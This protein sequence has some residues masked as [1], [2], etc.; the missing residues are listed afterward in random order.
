MPWVEYGYVDPTSV[1][2]P[3]TR[4]EPEMRVWEERRW[5]TGWAT[6]LKAAPLVWT[7]LFVDMCVI[8]RYLALS[9]AISCYLA[10]SPAISRH[11]A[12]LFLGKVTPKVPPK[13]Y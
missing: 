4:F 3:L 9:G 11:L 2:H 10:P 8:W 6:G 7:I 5:A 13:C 12:I 1:M